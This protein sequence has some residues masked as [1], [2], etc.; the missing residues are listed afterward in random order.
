M[1]NCL[2]EKKE[3][4]ATAPDQL[5]S[6]F[7]ENNSRKRVIN[8]KVLIVAIVIIAIIAIGTFAFYKGWLV[9]ATVNGSPISRL[10]IVAALEKS[11]GKRMLDAL[12]TQKVI[13]DEMR[14][15]GMT[16][17]DDEVS[18]DMKA[19]EDQIKAQGGNLDATLIA[20]G[21]TLDDFRK[22]ITIQKQLKKLLADK[23]QITDVEIEKFIADS[24]IAIPKG[25]EDSYKNDAK[26]YLERQKLSDEAGPLVEDLK[27]Q[28]A[29]RY[30]VNY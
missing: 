21:L 16:V 18:E 19:V 27:S 12:I 3:L 8:K 11:S 9:A 14:K 15:R 6:E 30:F 7:Q 17:T 4:S 5:M 25:K 2:E 28:S 1:E 24:D 20:Q 29:I 22:Q 26:K 13:D 23:I 10:A